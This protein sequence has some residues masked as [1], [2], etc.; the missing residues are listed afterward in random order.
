MVIATLNYFN[1]I[2]N[3][4]KIKLIFLLNFNSLVFF[5]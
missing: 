4:E 1:K 5:K 2:H 3:L